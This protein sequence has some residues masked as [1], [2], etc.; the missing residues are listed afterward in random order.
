M[1]S[2]RSRVLVATRVAATPAR[3]FEVFTNQIAQWWRPNALFQFT[4]GHNGTLRFEPGASGR[5]TETYDDGTV[6]EVGRVKVWE[7]PRRLVLSWRHASFEPDQETELEV[8]FDAVG[9]Q[10]RV[11]V[12]HFGWDTIP[13]PHV[14]RHGFPLPDFQL[15]L[16]EWWQHQLG[17]VASSSVTLGD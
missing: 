11:T 7:P 14:A 8:R 3:A 16:A 1:T 17:R 5:L 2:D 12:E 15:R 6:F 10:T 9:A 13:Q 4:A